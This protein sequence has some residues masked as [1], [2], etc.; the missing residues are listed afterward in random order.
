MRAGLAGLFPV[1]LLLFALA[2]CDARAPESMPQ[3]K[4]VDPDTVE[5]P[6]GSPQLT[7]IVTAQARPRGDTTLR[8]PGRIVWDEDHT[9]RVLSPL[10]GRVVS[11]AVK[12]GDRVRADQTLAVISAPELGTAQAEARKAE[13]DQTLAEKNLA[14]VRDLH[15]AG[16]VAAKDLAAAEAESARADAERARTTAR[17]KLFGSSPGAVD[18]QFELR[19]PIAGTVV[20]RNLNPGQELRPDQGGDKA[21]FVISDTSRLW[22]AL[23]VAEADVG[24]VKIGATIT[25]HAQLLGDQTAT[26]RITHIADFVDPVTRTVK[27]RGSVD[28]RDHRLKA[29]MFVTGELAL[30]GAPGLVVPSAAVFLRGDRYFVFVETAP[31]RFTRRPV[32]LG[33][34]YD[35]SQVVLDGLAATDTIVTDGALLLLRILA[36]PGQG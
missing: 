22:L 34:A 16:V 3:P 13:Q 24:A 14:R 36:T 9:V 31:G 10:A 4:I 7:S 5:F 27:V 30:K 32:R 15:E 12:P 18:Q 21:L 20:E 19:S 8:L 1:A 26:G 29:E 23:D 33:A 11:I 17:L 6:A 35:S 28:N 25:L 2:G